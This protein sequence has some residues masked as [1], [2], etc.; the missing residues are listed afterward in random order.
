MVLQLSPAVALLLSGDAVQRAVLAWNMGRED[1]RAASGD[2]WQLPVLAELLSDPYSVVRAIAW[3]AIRN[4][5]D[6]EPFKY[7]FLASE[8]ERLKAKQDL[9]ELWRKKM[10]GRTG[11]PDRSKM[12][13]RLLMQ[14]A[15]GE[16]DGTALQQLTK[17]R[18]D[19]PIN[20]AE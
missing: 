13:R 19:R 20:F 3:R 7:D 17:G 2:D 14:T 6:A 4:Y 9:I 11:L 5:P 15:K 8:E 10:A 12:E 16:R 1:T 18:D